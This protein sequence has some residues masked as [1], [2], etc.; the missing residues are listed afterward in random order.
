VIVVGSLPW[1]ELP[2]DVVTVLVTVAISVL[3]VRATAKPSSQTQPLTPQPEGMVIRAKAIT[4]RTIVMVLIH[5]E[6]SYAQVELV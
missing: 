4:M 3:L 5:R 6:G 2:I 1:S